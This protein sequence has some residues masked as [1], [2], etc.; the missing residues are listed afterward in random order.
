M[1]VIINRR[2]RET[3]SVVPLHI[4]K[5]RKAAQL[6]SSLFFVFMQKGLTFTLNSLL[7]SGNNGRS[8]KLIFFH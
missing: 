3:Q 6:K 7:C 8:I 2:D 5:Q 4:I 1:I